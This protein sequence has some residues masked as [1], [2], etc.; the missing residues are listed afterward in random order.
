MYG[1]GFSYARRVLPEAS[2]GSFG[3]VASD[4]KFVLEIAPSVIC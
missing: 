3:R 1:F 4:S 2:C